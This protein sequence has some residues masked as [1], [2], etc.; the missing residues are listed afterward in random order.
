MNISE[1]IA[2]SNVP[3][4]EHIVEHK[5]SRYGIMLPAHDDGAYYTQLF[6]RRLDMGLIKGDSGILAGSY[7]W[8]RKA[9]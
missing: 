6:T 1:A 4:R 2:L 3:P 8:T 5:G 9:E 7:S